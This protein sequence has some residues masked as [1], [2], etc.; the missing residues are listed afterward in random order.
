M[1]AMQNLNKNLRFA[2][3]HI[4]LVEFFTLI[5]TVPIRTHRND[6]Y[7]GYDHFPEGRLLF[8]KR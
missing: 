1:R 2:S 4:I 3:N 7:V 8:F 5:L 6:P